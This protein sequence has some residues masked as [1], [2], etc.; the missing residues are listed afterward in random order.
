MGFGNIKNSKAVIYS[1]SA[2]AIFLWGF[3]YIWSN[4]LIEYDIPIYYFV[5]IRIAIAGVILLLF[6]LV[7][8]QFQKIRSTKDLLLMLLISV[9]EPFIYFI[10]ETYGIKETAS[11]T[12]SSMVVATVPIF[13]LAVGYFAFKEKVTLVNVLGVLVTLG[14]LF[15]VLSAQIDT[16]IGPHFVLGMVLLFVAVIV[17]VCHASLVK[18]LARTYRPHV[19]VMY[20]FLIGSVYFIPLFLTEGIRNFTP[21]YLS[22]EVLRPILYLAVLCS[23]LAFGLWAATIKYLGV[24]KSSV[25]LALISIVTALVAHIMGQETLGLVQWV[26]VAISALGIIFSQYQGRHK[27]EPMVIRESEKFDSMYE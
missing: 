22:W 19:I 20:Q 9:C 24:A 2:L 12:I 23:A 21:F 8:R 18:H 13:S 7:T 5:T 17:E 3:S 26:G 25:F 15:L 1:F 10:A 4:Q 16:G 27:V 11:P 6:N 14:G